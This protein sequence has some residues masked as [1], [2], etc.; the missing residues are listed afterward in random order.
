MAY[1]ESAEVQCPCCWET[2]WIDVDP[3][4]GEHQSFIEDCEVCCRPIQY[5]AT[6]DE[7]GE[8]SVEARP[9]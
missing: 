4:G 3:S 8:V 9:S 5:N 7:D 6:I 1:R 2:I